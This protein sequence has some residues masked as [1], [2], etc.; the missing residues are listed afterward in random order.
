MFSGTLNISST[1]FPISPFVANVSGTW[2]VT[3]TEATQSGV[4][5][6]YVKSYNSGSNTWSTVGTNPLN[7]NTS[8]GIA[9]HPTIATDGT[10]VF[11]AWEEQSAIGQHALGHMKK[12]NGV[13]WS[14]LGGNIAADTTN[15]SVADLGIVYAG[16][17]LYAA[18][19][20]VSWGNLRQI[21]YRTLPAIDM[22]PLPSPI[23]R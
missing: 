20:E 11:A 12:W 13:S 9:Y 6:V 17:S 14:Q 2:Y 4:A 7:V 1:S 23:S 18:W 15:G 21:Y 3:W 16:S 8:T 5:K 19:T 10:N 22:W